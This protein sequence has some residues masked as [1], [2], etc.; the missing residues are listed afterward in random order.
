M[1]V[2]NLRFDKFG[3]LQ[4]QYEISVEWQL[5]KT[6]FVDMFP[7]SSSRS[8]L[9]E[10][11]EAF[12]SDLLLLSGESELHQYIDGSFISRKLEPNDMD[13]VNFIPNLVMEQHEIELATLK[14]N[15]YAQG[16]D[17]YYLVVY[18]EDHPRAPWT[19]SDRTRWQHLF[20]HVRVN[21]QG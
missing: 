7:A 11:Y 20:G 3:Y 14:A 8:K 5:L 2:M 12:S 15:Y 9:F 6:G 19:V 18:P 13:V 10:A 21:A 17:S 4:P 16:V 1:L